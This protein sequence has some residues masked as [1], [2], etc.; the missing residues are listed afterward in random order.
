MVP[1]RRGSPLSFPATVVVSNYF[2]IQMNKNK[3][4]KM[5]LG[6]KRRHQTSL[7]PSL[8]LSHGSPTPR[9]PIIIVVVVVPFYIIV[10]VTIYNYLD[11]FSL[12]KCK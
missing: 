4:K 3:K 6:P 7:G 11:F 8:G 2:L 5:N 9:C 1:C 12:V 10:D